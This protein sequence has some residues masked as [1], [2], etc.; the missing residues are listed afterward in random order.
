MKALMRT[1]IATLATSVGA[2]LVVLGVGAANA[3][4][5]SDDHGRDDHHHHHSVFAKRDDNAHEWIVVADDDD[6]GDDP[7]RLRGRDDH[8][9][10]GAG[11]GGG[12][13]TRTRGGTR[14][15]T[16]SRHHSHRDGDHSRGGKVRDWTHDGKGGHKRD[17]SANLTNDGS[18]H[19]TRGR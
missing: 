5:G 8:T 11:E 6:N 1:G 18:R 12:T 4:N 14:T 17:F 15:R 13:H 16:R 2:G 19:N 3:D 9:S 10:T 7:N